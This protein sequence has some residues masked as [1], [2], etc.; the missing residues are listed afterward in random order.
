[1]RPDELGAALVLALEENLTLKQ[2]QERDKRLLERRIEEARH[3]LEE[4]LAEYRGA[5][6][7]LEGRVNEMG[8]LASQKLAEARR[9]LAERV[10]EVAAQKPV[11]VTHTVE[12]VERVEVVSDGS[13]VENFSRPDDKDELV[14]ERKDGTKFRVKLPKR[15]VQHIDQGGGGGGRANVKIDNQEAELQFID[16]GLGYYTMR[17]CL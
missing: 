14:L 10:E 12:R 2:R 15:V 11:E 9:E 13:G 3:Q 1:M 16:S 4:A 5:V 7:G 8:E 17:V 6:D